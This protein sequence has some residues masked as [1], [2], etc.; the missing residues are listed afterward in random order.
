[1]RSVIANVPLEVIIND[2]IRVT[3]SRD[4]KFLRIYL[5]LY[6]KN[7]SIKIAFSIIIAIKKLNQLNNI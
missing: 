7:H 3:G 5:F 4:F 1:M 2:I 6:E